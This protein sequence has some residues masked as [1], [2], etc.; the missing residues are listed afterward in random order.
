MRCH[1]EGSPP[2]ISVF[3]FYPG[4]FPR[5]GQFF[6]LRCGNCGEKLPILPL[7]GNLAILESISNRGSALC[8]KEPRNMKTKSYG[9]TQWLMLTHEKYLAPGL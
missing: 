7:L 5:I 3:V 9:D 4:T 8:N 1:S 6:A 2:K